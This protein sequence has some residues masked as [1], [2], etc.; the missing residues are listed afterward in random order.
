MKQSQ[1]FTLIELITVLV[2]VGIVGVFGGLFMVKMVQSY[3]WAEDNAHL[4]QKAQVALTRIAVEMA[5][6]S[7]DSIV[8]S[9]YTISYDANYPGEGFVS[10]NEIIREADKLVFNG[11]VLTDRVESFQIDDDNLGHGY[12]TIILTM[13]G[14][15]SIDKFFEKTIAV[16]E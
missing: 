6:A 3:R 9:D 8:F 1:G 13:K 12:F 10:G 16:S 11:F 14:A 4:S 5:Y 7:G 15:N 2:L